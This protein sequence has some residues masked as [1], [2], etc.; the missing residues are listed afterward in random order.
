MLCYLFFHDLLVLSDPIYRGSSLQQLIGKLSGFLSFLL[1]GL[2]L[3]LQIVSEL[4]FVLDQILALLLQL[5]QAIVEEYHQSFL[6]LDVG[7][8]CL[9]LVRLVLVQL[10]FDQVVDVPLDSV[11]L[12]LCVVYLVQHLLLLLPLHFTIPRLLVEEELNL[13]Y[14]ILVGVLLLLVYHQ[15]LL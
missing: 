9:H 15:P 5:L 10:H 13:S 3:V 7:V 1:H 12:V 6:L 8:Q 2:P 11:N 4:L 14:P